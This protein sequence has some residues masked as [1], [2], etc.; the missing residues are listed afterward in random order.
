MSA[1][2][3]Q[4]DQPDTLIGALRVLR[5]RWF[6]VVASMVLCLLVAILVHQRHTKT[7]ESTSSVA[8][9]ISTLSDTALEVANNSA[10]PERDAATNVLIAK[11]PAVAAAVKAQ[12]KLPDSAQDLVNDVSVEAAANA[13]VLDI[14]AQ[15]TDPTRARQLADAFARQYIAFQARSQI[16]SIDSAEKTLRAQ[17]ET[18]PEGSQRANDVSTSLQRLAQLRAVASGNARVIGP[19]GDAAETGMGLKLMFALGLVIGLALGA[20]LA[21]VVEALD[22]RVTRIEDFERDLG[23]P[24]LAAVPQ[25][26]F[27]SPKAIDRRATLEPYRI[28]RSA[29]D[30]ANPDSDVFTVMVT[31]AAPGEGKT[32]VG[33]DL[34][35][36]VAL[37]GR[38][39]VLAELDLRRP[40]FSRHFDL[41]PRRGVTSVLWDR[42]TVDEALV[43]PM[44]DLPNLMV[45]PSG[46]L[47][48][49]P[50]E[51]L[52]SEDLE[53]LLTR[54]TFLGTGRQR[55][56]IIDAPPLLA[57]SDAQV[58]LNNPAI[59][60]VLLVARAGKTT[61]D[62][63]RR[64]RAVLSRH[65][66][67]PIGIVVTGTG[68]IKEYDYSSKDPSAGSGSGS[69]SG[70]QRTRSSAPP[71][72]TGDA[73]LAEGDVA[74]RRPAR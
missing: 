7:Y 38:S 57:V 1:A 62:D 16:E 68:D 63:V 25:S 49:N 31:S 53:N 28:L 59:D 46:T 37:T 51:L 30:I 61:H 74:V 40:T 54:L 47:P 69:G 66:L 5:R 10:N 48:P 21:F 24:A 29:L 42:C 52:D 19:A 2:D 41:D 34:A 43:S 36:A 4:L 70:S 22:R 20:T 27:R 44:A 23:L 8:F 13:D 6:V 56:I 17:L 45:L 11:S 65:L 35:Q 26:S 64:A 71:A 14:T 72:S 18:L 50:S 15:S 58:L 55:M 12:L 60:R 9:G 33:V 39:V 32:T 3:T 73:E 67:Q